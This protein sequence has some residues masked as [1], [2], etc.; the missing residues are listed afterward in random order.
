VHS[1]EQQ[2]INSTG[3]LLEDLEQRLREHD[4]NRRQSMWGSVGSNPSSNGSFSYYSPQQ[5][6]M[7]NTSVGQAPQQTPP[8]LVH[9]SSSY[10]GQQ[11]SPPLFQPQPSIPQYQPQHGMQYAYPQ[12]AFPPQPQ[13]PFTFNEPVYRNTNFGT[14]PNQQFANWGGYGGPSVPDTLDE[15]NAVPPKSNPW[16]MNSK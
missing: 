10:D 4:N 16:E 5:V 11:V 9:H 2:Y 6:R 3:P 7:S 1:W 12:Q 15:E 14:A 13:Q 8:P